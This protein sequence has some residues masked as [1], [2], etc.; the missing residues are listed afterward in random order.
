MQAQPAHGFPESILNGFAFAAAE[1]GTLLS[2]LGARELAGISDPAM[3]PA[4]AALP[5]ALAGLKQ[6]GWITPTG[7]DAQWRVD[8]VLARVLRTL[9]APEFVVRT[10]ADL[11]T[12]AGLQSRAILHY[13]AGPLIVELAVLA[14]QRYHLGLLE[15]RAALTQRAA[16]L[17]GVEDAPSVASTLERVP[18]LRGE[19][20]VARARDAAL[21]SARKAQASGGNWLAWR[22][23]PQATATTVVALDVA[24]LG[25]VLAEFTA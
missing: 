17:L 19:F 14:E 6:V 24:A 1:L 2:L 8:A 23:S 16:R 12:A 18:G 3:Q 13:I 9:I 4:A 11:E 22:K 21:L 7:E 20:I 15:S 5:P 25:R 10:A